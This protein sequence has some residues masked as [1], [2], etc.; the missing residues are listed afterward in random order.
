[1]LLFTLKKEGERGESFFINISCFTEERRR[2]IDYN[3]QYLMKNRTATARWQPITY[4][5][6]LVLELRRRQIV[7][8]I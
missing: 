2:K 5:V 7:T 1:M 4:R 3:F 6:E 8:S